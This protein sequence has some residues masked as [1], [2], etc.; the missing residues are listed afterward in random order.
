MV[1]CFM[2]GIKYY[3]NSIYETKEIKINNKNNNK[4]I[5]ENK[6]QLVLNKFIDNPVNEIIQKLTAEGI[7][8]RLKK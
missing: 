3:E 2:V 8:L 4:E 6:F 1:K 5:L 7:E